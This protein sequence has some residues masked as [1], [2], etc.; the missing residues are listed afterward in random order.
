[1]KQFLFE[2]MGRVDLLWKIVYYG[3]S[4]LWMKC[5]LILLLL[6]LRTHSAFLFIIAIRKDFY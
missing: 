5:S 6:L 2:E 3:A 4:W 1:L